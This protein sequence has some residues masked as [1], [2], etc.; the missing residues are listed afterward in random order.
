MLLAV[1]YCK[2]NC[3]YN[4]QVNYYF[5][6]LP[7]GNRGG[8][9]SSPGNSVSIMYWFSFAMICLTIPIS[10]NPSSNDNCRNLSISDDLMGTSFFMWF[11][12][13][14]DGTR[15]QCVYV[16]VDKNESSSN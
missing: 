9:L 8:S 6:H 4:I 1:S 15:T 12:K 13:V 10:S 11:S 3:L 16:Y 2:T 5:L 14:Q 7:S